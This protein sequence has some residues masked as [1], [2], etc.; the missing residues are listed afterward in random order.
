M[1]DGSMVGLISVPNVRSAMKLKRELPRASLA[2]VG[3]CAVWA[4]GT[5]SDCALR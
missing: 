2:S 1:V 4:I 3:R 5:Q